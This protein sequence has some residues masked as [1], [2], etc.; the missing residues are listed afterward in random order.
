MSKTPGKMRKKTPKTA[1]SRRRQ[2][3]YNLKET[4]TSDKME[5]IILVNLFLF[6]LTTTMMII[7]LKTML[8]TFVNR[9][10]HQAAHVNKHSS[11]I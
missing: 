8:Y 7:M 2:H 3:S 5:L 4:I 1:H 6:K 11:K 9:T 10:L